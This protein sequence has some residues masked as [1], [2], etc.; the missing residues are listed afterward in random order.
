VVDRN[1]R[2]LNVLYKIVFVIFFNTGII[3]ELQGDR[4]GI[5]NLNFMNSVIK[6]YGINRILFFMREMVRSFK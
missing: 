4:Q 3:G 1:Y 6:S 5:N 2:F